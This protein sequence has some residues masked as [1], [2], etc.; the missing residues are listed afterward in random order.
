MKNEFKLTVE[1]KSINESFARVVVSAFVT[2][3]DPLEEL[4]DL[5]TAVSEEFT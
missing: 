5:K 2:P 1:S 3:L 4:A